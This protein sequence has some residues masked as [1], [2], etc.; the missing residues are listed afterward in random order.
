MKRSEA[1]ALKPY[2]GDLFED[3][4]RRYVHLEDDRAILRL[5]FVHGK[6]IKEISEYLDEHSTRFWSTR[7]IWEVKQTYGKFLF[8]LYDKLHGVK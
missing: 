1:L 5:Y 4:I 2:D 8:D 6:S 7:Q 3:M